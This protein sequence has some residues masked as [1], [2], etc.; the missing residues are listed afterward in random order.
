MTQLLMVVTE[1]GDLKFCIAALNPN[2][3]DYPTM[4]VTNNKAKYEL[5]ILDFYG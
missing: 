5:A 3:S 1:L 4:I 2:L